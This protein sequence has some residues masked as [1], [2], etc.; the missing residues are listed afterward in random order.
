MFIVRFKT[1]VLKIMVITGSNDEKMLVRDEPIISIDTNKNPMA[2]TVEMRP[3]DI[4]INNCFNDIGFKFGR[5]I[6]AN[7][8]AANTIV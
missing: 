3:K 5:N 1:N 2:T 8:I 6:I 4:T 7:D